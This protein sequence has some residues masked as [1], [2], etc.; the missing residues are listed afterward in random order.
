MLIRTLLALALAVAMLTAP[1]AADVA[2][3][4]KTCT[5]Q[6]E[7][8]WEQQVKSCTEIIDAKE[9][10]QTD[11]VLALLRRGI[12]RL[13]LSYGQPIDDATEEVRRA[14]ADFDASIKLDPTRATTYYYRGEAWHAVGSARRALAEYTQAI[15]RNADLGPAYFGRARV[16]LML[17]EYKN[18]VAD[19]T[20]AIRLYP[21]DAEPYRAR[22][23]IHNILNDFPAAIADY[24]QAI[25]LDPKFAE[26]YAGRGRILAE[27]GELDRAI[28]DLTEAIALEPNQGTHPA[29]RGFVHF[30]RGDFA[31]SAADLHKAVPL[32]PE[33]IVAQYALV[34]RYLARLR[35]GEDGNTEL[36]ATV[37][38][39]KFPLPILEF[40][41]GRAPLEAVLNY[42]NS[43]DRRC[44]TEFYLAQWHIIRSERDQAL[45]R[46]RATSGT[47]CRPGSPHRLAALAELKRM[48][49]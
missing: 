13:E 37:K 12:A 30:Y 48:G 1:A 32:D 31:A 7:V 10:T 33:G 23:Y 34:F 49:L 39:H 43:P 26:A 45:P 8:P 41:L 28:A 47:L 15:Q 40:F 16:H 21:D 38:D 19:Y 6:P 11:R 24:T 22:A 36:A 20:Q 46:L 44:E 27:I 3:L 35:A 18:A 5:G 29:H 17:G 25:R 14:M 4:F 9:A 42:A 2:S